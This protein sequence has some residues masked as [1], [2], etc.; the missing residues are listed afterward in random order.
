MQKRSWNVTVADT[1]VDRYAICSLS[2]SRCS[3][4]ESKAVLSTHIHLF[5]GTSLIIT[6]G[7]VLRHA[8]A[9]PFLQIDGGRYSSRSIFHMQ[10]IMES[11]QYPQIEGRPEHP[12]AAV[13]RDRANCHS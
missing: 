10:S 12:H 3:T 9:E 5:S 4:R 6:A 11:L 2:W 7:S 8:N 1:A 13:L